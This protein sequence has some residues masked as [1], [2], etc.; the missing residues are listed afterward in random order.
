MTEHRTSMLLAFNKSLSLKLQSLDQYK[1]SREANDVFF[2]F[3][4]ETHF[5]GFHFTL[6]TSTKSLEVAAE[7]MATITKR[8]SLSRETAL[9][10]F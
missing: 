4:Y 9:S 2:L 5:V 6:R 10:P 7:S 3:C 1:S 8:H